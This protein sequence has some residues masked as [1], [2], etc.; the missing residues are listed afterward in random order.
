VNNHAEKLLKNCFDPNNF[1]LANWIEMQ[2]KN[3]Q[4]IT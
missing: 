4:A 3:G 2:N 1:D